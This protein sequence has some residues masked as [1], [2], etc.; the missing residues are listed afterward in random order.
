MVEVRIFK[1]NRDCIFRTN[2]E[3]KDITRQLYEDGFAIV[4]T[5]QGD[6]LVLGKETAVLREMK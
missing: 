3:V 4:P 1:S 5:V 6:T 2:M